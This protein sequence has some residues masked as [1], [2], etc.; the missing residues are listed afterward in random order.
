MSQF[1]VPENPPFVGPTA[2]ELAFAHLASEL[3]AS[4]TLDS[5]WMVK[6]R[7]ESM[8]SSALAQIL[9]VILIHLPL[10]FDVGEPEYPARAILFTDTPTEKDRGTVRVILASSEHALA[11]PESGLDEKL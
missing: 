6:V 8:S 11:T 5:P 4:A 7:F 1:R 2:T 3:P 10:R 9:G